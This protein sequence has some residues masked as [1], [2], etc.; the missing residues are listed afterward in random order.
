VASTTQP[1]EH[2]LDDP[3]RTAHQQRM[4]WMPWLYDR[5]KPAQAA[6]AR[7]WQAEVQAA[8]A[9]VEQ[10]QFGE[11]VFV[12]PSARLFAEPHRDI[13]V[14]DGCRIAAEAFL[15]GPLSLGVGVSLNARV[16]LDGGRA[17]IQIGDHSRIAADVKMY[18]F[19]HG[20]A[21]DRLVREQP[22]RSRG[23]SVGSDVWVGA[24]VCITDGVRIGDHAVVGMG[25]VVTRDIPDWA[26]AVGVPAEVV[27][28]RRTWSA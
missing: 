9:A 3:Y 26:V 6:W 27:G 16:I 1:L 20:I 12:A 8:I 24:G 22:V 2:V 13:V 11:D 23:I 15:H 5:L 7:P 19:D 14:G 10:V 28:D 4:A 25:A 21:P 17:G 18:A